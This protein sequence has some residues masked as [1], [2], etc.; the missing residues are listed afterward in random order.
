MIQ[1]ID[2]YDFIALIGPTGVG[3]SKIA[4]E[5][6]KK[7]KGDIDIVCMD[8]CQVYK[9]AVIGT[10]SPSSK[11]KGKVGFHLYN[12]L[13][14][15]VEFSAGEYAEI[16]VRTI[17][18]LKRNG[19]IPMLVGG[20][21]FFLSSLINSFHKL[22]DVR[23]DVR[24]QVNR[25]VHGYGVERAFR[26]LKY[27]DPAAAKTVDRR[28][29][30]RVSRALEIIFQTKRRLSD[31]R[32]NKRVDYGLRG[33]IFGLYIPLKELE[34][35]IEERTKDMINRGFILEVRKL[36]EMGFDLK[37]PVFKAIGYEYIYH[38]LMGALSLNNATKL[39]IRDTK[40]YAKRQM[41]W[42][43]RDRR[44]WWLPTIY[45]IDGTYDDYV[46]FYGELL[47]NLIQKNF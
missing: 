11:E 34:G 10:D 3:K 41:T 5:V 37:N 13:S 21:G 20:T 12:F 25:I 26:L 30:S 14:P 2:N 45:D 29:P 38:Y 24:I 1:N 39:I 16:A 33:L 17:R 32:K 40:S 18:K 7:V 31:I 28:N 8:S 47:S 19:R 22:P 42:F 27:L 23:D 4:F 44:V 35:R 6:A 15:S 46:S 36:M 9:F 43:L